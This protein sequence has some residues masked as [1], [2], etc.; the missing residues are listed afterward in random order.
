MAGIGNHSARFPGDPHPDG[1]LTGDGS[2]DTPILFADGRAA[3]STQRRAV[4][5]QIG[6]TGVGGTGSSG[7]G[8]AQTAAAAS[9]FVINI[10]W[11]ASVAAAP[12]GFTAGI[13]AAVQYLESQFTDPVTITINVGYGEIGGSALEAHA[14]GESA[15]Y[16]VRTSYSALRNALAADAR[17]ATDAA[18]VASLPAA[19]PIGGALWTTTAE[20]KALG[21][22]ASSAVSL[23]G[24]IGFSGAAGMFDYNDADGVTAGTHDFNA[25]ALHEITEVMGR[26]LFTGGTIGGAASYTALDLFHYSSAGVR[27]FAAATPGFFSVDGGVTNLG[28]FNTIAGGDAG[29]WAPSMGNDAFDAYSNSG[30]VDP[31]TAGDLTEMDAVGWDHLAPAAAG[32]TGVAIS[33]VTRSLTRL[34]GTNGLNGYGI[35]GTA[36]PV[37]AL[38]GHTYTFALGGSGAAPFRVVR[39]ESAPMLQAGPAGAAGGRNGTLYALTL[40][41]TDAATGASSP[42]APL[43]VIVGSSA[44]DTVHVAALVGAATSATPTFVYGLAGADRIDA[45][46]MTGNLWLVGGAGADTMSGGTGVNH[47]LYGATSEST[48]ASIDVIT[49]FHAATDLLDLTGIGTVLSYAGN[50]AAAKL[51]AHSIG[52]QVSGGNTFVYANTSSV[53]EA[54][55][56]ANMKIE[57]QGSV[58][59]SSG[60]ILHL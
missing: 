22:L 50:I 40:S 25:V 47:Y 31:V 21:L 12:A 32:P 10:Q 39:G 5:G 27:D 3:S 23:D 19:S 55:G 37:A 14:L 56:A 58:A 17:T 28:Q 53:S 15:S 8:T 6:A 59:L 35:L 20:A 9:P 30:V 43:D 16:I 42:P 48:P 36:A 44:A 24:N 33:P 41:A 45:T 1:Y 4:G 2:I 18:A 34:E 60:N 26:M 54:Q 49:N 29:D 13:L 7:T 52:W 11:D 38:P 51:A 46:G 57:L